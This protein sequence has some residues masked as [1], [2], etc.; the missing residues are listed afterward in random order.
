MISNNVPVNIGSEQM[1]NSGN[2]LGIK[3][4]NQI[5]KTM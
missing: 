5:L 3:I 4:P 2:I 1:Q